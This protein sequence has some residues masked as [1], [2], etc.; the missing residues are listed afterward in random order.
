MSWSIERNISEMNHF[1]GLS[2]NG[3]LFAEDFDLPECESNGR[4]PDG[5]E[6]DGCEPEV[7]A[8]VF[9]PAQ[10]AAAKAASFDEGWAAGRAALLAEDAAGLRQAVETLSAELEAARQAARSIGEQAAEAVAR[11]LLAALGVVMP[12]LCAS[13]GDAEANAVARIVLP[14]LNGE[15]EIIIRAHPRTAPGLLAAIARID[16]DLA[17]RVRLTPTDAMAP[18]DLRIAWQDGLAVRDGAALWREVAA[19]LLPQGLL[20]TASA[21]DDINRDDLNRDDLNR[22]DLNQD[23]FN[24]KGT[25]YGD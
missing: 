5:R 19:I 15:P 16:P 8:P 10:M 24:T 4:D 17:A 6:A 12:A 11:L 7:I 20:A 22:D 25:R 23:D 9:D 14:A 1:A 21:P 3:V 2:G 18:G 13:Y